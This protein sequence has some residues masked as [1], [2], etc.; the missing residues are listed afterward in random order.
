M[1]VTATASLGIHASQTGPAAPRPMDAAQRP[2][3]HRTLATAAK[4]R[5]PLGCLAP[6]T[7][8]KER[9]EGRGTVRH[10]AAPDADT[11]RS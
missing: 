7:A 10:A 1:A 5:V 3:R 9:G 8:A 4:V 6:D 2:S 11:Y